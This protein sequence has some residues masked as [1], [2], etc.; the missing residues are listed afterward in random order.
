MGPLP[1]KWV[2]GFRA[3]VTTVWVSGKDMIIRYL[4]P[5]GFWH[6]RLRLSDHCLRD[7]CRS[8]GEVTRKPWGTLG[9]LREYWGDNGAYYC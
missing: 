2:L 5:W 8:R 7:P 3:I 1:N 9:K 6:L 4:D